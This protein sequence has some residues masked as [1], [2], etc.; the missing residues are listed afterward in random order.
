MLTH[1]S[2]LIHPRINSRVENSHPGTCSNC[3]CGHIYGA[4]VPGVCPEVEIISKMN[5]VRIER[6]MEREFLSVFVLFYSSLQAQ[7]L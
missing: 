4:A 5:L 1:E 3:T 2:M 6:E 7:L